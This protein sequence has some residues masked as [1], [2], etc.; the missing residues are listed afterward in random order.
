MRTDFVTAAAAATLRVP[1]L[2][3][4]RRSLIWTPLFA[5]FVEIDVPASL[6]LDLVRVVVARRSVGGA[7]QSSLPGAAPA[8]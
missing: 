3:C 6:L 2:A 4:G 5:S 7:H 8:A 1:L